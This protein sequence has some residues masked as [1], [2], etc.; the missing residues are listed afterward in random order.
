M[1]EVVGSGAGRVDDAGLVVVQQKGGDLG[2]VVG[3]DGAV[4]VVTLAK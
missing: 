2:A 1:S 4:V 3:S